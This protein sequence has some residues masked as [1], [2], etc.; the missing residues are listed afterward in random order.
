[1]ERSLLPSTALGA[2]RAPRPQLFLAPL[3]KTELLLFPFYI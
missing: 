3:C 1:M 2:L